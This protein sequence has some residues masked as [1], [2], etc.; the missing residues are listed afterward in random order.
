[1]DGMKS[2]TKSTHPNVSI[3]TLRTV[4]QHMIYGLK[5]PDKCR[6]ADLICNMADKVHRYNKL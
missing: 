5:F 6:K 1:M 2:P 4:K 3:F